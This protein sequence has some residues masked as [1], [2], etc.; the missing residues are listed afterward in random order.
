MATPVG[1]TPRPI[2]TPA[3]AAARV[4]IT[5]LRR[6][7]TVKNWFNHNILIVTDGIHLSP[8][9]APGLAMNADTRLLAK[10]QSTDLFKN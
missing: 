9:G 5:R 10:K 1:T 7:K 6:A 3:E 2:G 8:V 4:V